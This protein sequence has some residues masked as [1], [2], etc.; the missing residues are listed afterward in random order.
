[1]GSWRGEDS[2]V[3]VQLADTLHQPTTL[4]GG[5]SIAGPAELP[6]GFEEGEPEYGSNVLIGIVD[7][8]GFDFSHPDFV[9]NGKT[10]F[11]RIWDQDGDFRHPPDFGHSN[12]GGHIKFDYGA[13]ITAEHM[14]YAISHAP[15]AGLPAYQLEPQTQMVRGS[16]GTHVASIAAGNHSPCRNAKI[17]G[18]FLA[19]PTKDYHRRLS[20]YDTTRIAM[21]WSTCSRWARSL[22]PMR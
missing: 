21:R 4:T 7:V 20:F 11:V 9:R 14:N 22:E 17:A 15:Q 1:M 13:E 16:H 5:E 2:V 6:I 18:V 3:S 12:Q 8:G 10:R 19:L